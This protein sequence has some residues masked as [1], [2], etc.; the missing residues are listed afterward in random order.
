MRI[1]LATGLLPVPPTYFALQHGE[2]LQAEHEVRMFALAAD[3]RDP[4]V[5]VEVDAVLPSVGPWPARMA[6]AFATAPLSSAVQSRRIADFEPDVVHQHFAT[7]SR[8]ALDGAARAAAPLVATLHGYDVFAAEGTSRSRL[9]RFHRRSVADTAARADRLLAV[10]RYLADRAIAAGFPTD[11]LEVHYQGIDTEAFTPGVG[12]AD[13]DVPSIVFIG[14]LAE[15]KGVDDLIAASVAIAVRAPHRLCII[16]SGPLGERV[17]AVASEYPHIDVLGSLPRQAVLAHLR[18]ARALV[19][20]T[21]LHEGWREAA[22]LVLLEAQACGV[23]V[24]TYRSGGAPEMVDEGITGLVVD[25]RD[26]AALGDAI[27][28][29]ARLPQREWAAMSAHARAFVVER[30]SLA[31]SVDELLAHYAAVA[32]P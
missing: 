29:L 23:P 1:A 3:I 9:E 20:P 10:S 11:R 28:E 21:R 24:V 15:R 19:L 4:A 13:G 14:A 25:E 32:A 12:P 17:R 26:V 7:W 27:A 22:G 16:G 31:V 18:G 8:G 2:R 5:T 30:R 6:A